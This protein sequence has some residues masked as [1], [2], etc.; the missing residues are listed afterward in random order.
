MRILFT[1]AGG[2]GHLDPLVPLARAAHAAGHDIVFVGRPWM[3][4]IVRSLGFEAWPAGSDLGLTPVSR[5]LV[6]FDLEREQR[7]LRDGF[8]GR[9]A[10]ER[11]RDLLAL[12]P[13]GPPDLIV[14]EETDFGAAIV[15]ERLGVPHASVL[16]IASG[17]FVRADLL[18]ATLD[19]VRREHGL[20]A[21]PD[22]AMLARYLVLSP[23]PASLRDPDFPPPATVHGLGP[24]IAPPPVAGAR[25]AWTR[26]IPGAPCIY[27]TFGTVFNHESGDLFPRV[28]AGLG[29]L[30]ANVL[31]TVGREID[32]VS[33]GPQPSHIRVE[34]F[35]PQDEVLP[36][37]DVVVSHAGSGSVVGALAFGR[38]MVL[39][40]IGAD[41][42]LNAERCVATGVG[43]SLDPM[44]ATP[45]DVAAAVL[46]ML[47]DP[48]YRRRAE[49]LRDEIA[50]LPSPAAVVPLLERLAG[51][52]R[53]I[54]SVV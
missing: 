41:Q 23:F 40:P 13:D 2:R 5:E 51:D 35:V 9:I 37:V 8:V 30:R 16:V 31:V 32:P 52:R 26:T 10:R 53:A 3:L 48:A 28:L 54:P 6:P 4:P 22:A 47:G 20:P 43:R 17:S 7:A 21:D 15:A 44:Q 12:E 42:P 27:V 11:A 1:F 45:E 14:W 33:L 49:G 46:A 25:P 50:A 36:F 24:G 19:D 34:R 38:P 39:L 29:P 18:A